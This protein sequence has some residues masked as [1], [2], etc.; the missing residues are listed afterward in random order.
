MS[1]RSLYVVR[2]ILYGIVEC[3]E[4][5]HMYIVILRPRGF[6]NNSYLKCILQWDLYLIYSRLSQNVYRRHCVWLWWFRDKLLWLFNWFNLISLVLLIND[7]I[8]MLVTS[9]KKPSTLLLFKF[10]YRQCML[11]WELLLKTWCESDIKYKL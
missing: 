11:E 1:R 2:N 3:L 10:A 8:R 5:H 9:G 4:S 7:Y 6:F